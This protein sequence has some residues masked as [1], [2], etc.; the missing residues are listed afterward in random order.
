MPLTP[1]VGMKWRNA[2]IKT[3]LSQE[4]FMM[5]NSLKKMGKENGGRGWI[6]RSYMRKIIH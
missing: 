4:C 3:A 1:G 5:G 2:L 6:S